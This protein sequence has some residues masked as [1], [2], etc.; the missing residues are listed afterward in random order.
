MSFKEQS[1]TVGSVLLLPPLCAPTTSMAVSAP[2]EQKA[3]AGPNLGE[4]AGR[5]VPGA[6]TV[7]TGQ[8]GWLCRPARQPRLHGLAVD[9]TQ[10]GMGV[11]T[12]RRSAGL[13]SSLLGQTGRDAVRRQMNVSW[14]EH[15]PWGRSVNG[16]FQPHG[17]SG[18]FMCLF[19]GPR[20]KP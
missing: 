20:N 2:E 17:V 3:G 9:C 10:S 15:S 8:E 19:I 11:G 18:I 1:A 6:V 12:H 13:R 14:R 7:L 16:R 5:P 4:D